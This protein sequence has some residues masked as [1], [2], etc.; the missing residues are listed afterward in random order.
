MFYCI[1]LFELYITLFYIIHI[2]LYNVRCIVWSCILF[3]SIL[4]Y[5][6]VLGVQSTAVR[7]EQGDFGYIHTCIY[8]YFL[9]FHGEPVGATNRVSEQREFFLFP[10]QVSC[11]SSNR[12]ASCFYSENLGNLG[13]EWKR[14]LSL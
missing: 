9:F 5:C 7:Q 10:Q 11:F 14:S 1:V 4:L 3:H 13:F 2:I 6:I 8:P 12:C